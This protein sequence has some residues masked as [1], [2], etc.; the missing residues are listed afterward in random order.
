MRV[1]PHRTELAQRFGPHGLPA[2]ELLCARQP[3]QHRAERVVDLGFEVL[4]ALSGQHQAL[5]FDPDAGALTQPMFHAHAPAPAGLRISETAG[6]IDQVAAFFGNPGPIERLPGRNPRLPD[7]HAGAFAL[8]LA[9]RAI[10]HDFEFVIAEQQFDIVEIIAP[11]AAI[12]LERAQFPVAIE[13]RVPSGRQRPAQR[14]HAE[15]RRAVDRIYNAVRG[16]SRNSFA[17]VAELVDALP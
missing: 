14:G 4:A 6:K 2:T 16:I 11:V 10:K 9:L 7:R 13:F 8:D 1:E 17:Q 12:R 15:P 3:D 5:I